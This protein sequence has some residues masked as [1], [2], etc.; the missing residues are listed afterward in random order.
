MNET[1][2]SPQ[3]RV[4][5]VDDDQDFVSGVVDVLESR[6]Y[7]VEAVYSAKDALLRIEQF[8]A[9]V[10]LLDIRLGADKGTELISELRSAR[11]GLICV[12]MTAFAGTDSAI[13][14]L[15]QGAYDYLRK[16]IDMRELLS[17]LDRCFDK[18][19]LESERKLALEELASRN[20]KLSQ[21]NERLRAIVETT[22]TLAVCSG[23]KDMGRTILTEFARNMAAEGGSLFLVRG[24]SLILVH[25]LDPG[26][27]P[28]S[29]SLPMQKDSVF[30]RA[31]VEKAP[32][33]VK[34]F[35]IEPGFLP[36]GWSQYKDSSA[37]VLPLCKDN[38]QLMGILS[39]HNKA[40]P[41]FTEQDREIAL[42][43]VSYTC[44]A[45]RATHALEK[46]RLSESRFRL[47]YDKAPVM[48]H[49]IDQDGVIR[50]VNRK[51]L[52]ELG[53]ERNEVIG[54]KID[55]ILTPES[56]ANLYSVL[57]RFWLDGKVSGLEYQYVRKDGGC[58]DILLDSVIMDDRAWGRVSLSVVRDVTARKQAEKELNFERAQF[59]S[60]FDS[61]QAIIDVIDPKTHELL[62]MNKYARDMF[63]GEPVGKKCY[64]VYHDYEAPCA[65]CAND[66]VMALEGEPYRW[67]YPS[68]KL[69]REFMT[70]N[71]M[72]RWPDGRDVKLE[73]SI[74]I[75]DR[76]KAESAL[77][78]SE[79]KYRGL[80][81]DVGDAIIVADA[82]SFR[83]VDANEAAEKLWGYSR[84]EL[85][86]MRTQ[87]LSAE[88]QKTLE[89]LRSVSGAQHLAIPVLTHKKKDGTV[90]PVEMSVSA[91]HWKQKQFTCLILRDVS[92]RRKAEDIMIRSERLKAIADLS[93]GVSHNFNNLLQI[94]VGGA[95]LALTELQTGG[96]D[97]ARATLESILESTRWGAETVRRLQDFVQSSRKELLETATFDLSATVEKAIE[98]SKPWWKTHPEKNGVSIDLSQD[99]QRDCMIKG[100]ENEIFEVVIN[101]IKNAVEA[102]P[103]GGSLGIAAA[104][105]GD[106]VELTIRD[107]GSGISEK[108]RGQIFEPFF[109]TKGP[110]GTGMGLASSY[111]IVSRHGGELSF[112][113]EPNNG[114][115][116]TVRLPCSP[117]A[118][119]AVRPMQTRESLRDLL[120]LVIDDMEPIANLFG[121]ALRHS[122]AAV[123]TALSGPAALEFLGQTWADVVICDLAMPGMNGWETGRAI[124]A[125]AKRK[126]VAKPVFI[127]F[128]GWSDIAPD[129]E[130]LSECGVDRVIEKPV[131]MPKILDAIWELRLAAITGER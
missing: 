131:D 64:R 66:T 110:G 108:D 53:Y 87:D 25:S 130:Q 18:V 118:A 63:G 42:I 121:H 114:T 33:L 70:T 60:V 3:P 12:M 124:K 105:V 21:I 7:D 96:L 82:E 38:G 91:F 113:S 93:S 99:L 28:P 68:E 97:E 57:P 17:T 67:E 104:V 9:Q 101:L 111:G 98:M 6:D 123:H 106:F 103:N 78:E 47:V 10:A 41:P 8:D 45:L 76:K 34:N 29:I 79:E 13:E 30:N 89:T 55:F 127:L 74:D 26:H 44:E 1:I 84:E 61:I 83:I 120:V 11:P 16:P 125:L 24:D 81:S 75:T 95:S 90:F 54:R 23:L 88:P 35:E 31:I 50:N 116:F 5:V 119:A 71:R 65:F 58:I 62:F 102:M 49:S 36:S 126:G 112:V 43:L 69:G 109:S 52:S 20:L 19:R 85:L 122:V 72:I 92:E 129:N 51:W 46:L 32:V 86:Q 77:M 56:K 73:I 128:T 59:L 4:L 37:L 15:Q 107:S 2:V 80:F 100:K 115:T 39:L 27:A 94:V 40:F 117:K 22:K 14:A 48:M